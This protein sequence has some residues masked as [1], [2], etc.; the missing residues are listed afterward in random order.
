[1]ETRPYIRLTSP[2]VWRPH[3]P[4]EAEIGPGVFLAGYNLTPQ[5]IRSG[6]KVLLSIFWRS[7][8]M[9]LE[10]KVKVFVHVR[11][12]DDKN[13]IQ[14]DHWI[15]EH[16]AVPSSRWERIVANDSIVRDDFSLNLPAELS[17]GTYGILVGLYNPD[18]LERLPVVN[19]Q[20]GENAVYVGDMVIW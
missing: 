11:D 10:A 4:L 8:Q 20:F 15:L 6:D 12:A 16:F 3:H 2:F 19:D 14:A 1:M 9:P 17:P 18:N 7:D 13:V 5:R